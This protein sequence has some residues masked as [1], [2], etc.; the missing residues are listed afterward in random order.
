M[1]GRLLALAVLLVLATPGLRAQT[2]ADFPGRVFDAASRDG[3]QNLQVKLTPPRQSKAPI[4]IAS[5]ARDGGFEF[6]RLQRGRYLVEVSQGVTL[7]YRAEV[8]T[9][10]VSRL[11]IALKRK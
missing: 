4:R 1:S 11:D 9:T 7:L 3:I 2:A 8:D 5:T 10:K 6:T